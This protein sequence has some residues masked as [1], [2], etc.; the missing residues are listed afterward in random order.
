METEVAGT[1]MHALQTLATSPFRCPP[2]STFGL[3]GID[4]FDEVS[5]TIRQSSIQRTDV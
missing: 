3:P 4:R 1:G 5:Q 2:S